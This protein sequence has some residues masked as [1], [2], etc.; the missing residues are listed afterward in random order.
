MPLPQ[1]CFVHTALSCTR[2]GLSSCSRS[3]L[4]LQAHRDALGIVFL[5]DAASIQF[6]K[7]G[8]DTARVEGDMQMQELSCLLEKPHFM[9]RQFSIPCM[10]WT[11]CAVMTLASCLSTGATRL[12]G[13]P[14]DLCVRA[15][16]AG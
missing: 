12:S 9:S 10:G 6:T 16:P 1:P 15:I 8:S 7:S 5:Q 4:G 11:R 14:G 2:M 13:W 3:T